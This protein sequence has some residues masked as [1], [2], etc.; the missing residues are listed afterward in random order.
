MLQAPSSSSMMHLKNLGITRDQFIERFNELRSHDWLSIDAIQWGNLY[1]MQSPGELSDPHVAASS[2]PVVFPWDT[3]KVSYNI[4]PGKDPFMDAVVVG[5]I[6][7]GVVGSVKQNVKLSAALTIQSGVLQMSSWPTPFPPSLYGWHQLLVDLW[8]VDPPGSVLPP[9]YQN[10]PDNNKYT[11][12]SSDW[13]WVIVNPGCVSNGGVDYCSLKSFSV[14]PTTVKLDASGNTVKPNQSV[15]VS[16]EYEAASV[17]I[18]SRH[19]GVKGM[20]ITI[21][22]YRAPCSMGR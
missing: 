4:M 18:C 11:L 17:A 16:W 12:Q 6:A 7:D 5:R 14:V 13:T 3:V 15:T 2:V 10:P 22:R 8:V 19:S 21:K 9:E 1:P 20:G